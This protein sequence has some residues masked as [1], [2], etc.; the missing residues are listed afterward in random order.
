MRG[1]GVEATWVCRLCL[2][3]FLLDNGVGDSNGLDARPAQ[4]HHPRRC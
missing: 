2:L 1:G 3:F 4:A